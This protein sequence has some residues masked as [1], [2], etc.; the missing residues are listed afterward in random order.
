MTAAARKCRPSYSSACAEHDEMMGTSSV[1]L[2]FPAKRP[3]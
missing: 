3:N 2:T 1:A